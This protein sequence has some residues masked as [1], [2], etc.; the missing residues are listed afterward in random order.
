MSKTEKILRRARALAAAVALVSLPA[1]GNDAI[2][3]PDIGGSDQAA[4]SDQRAANIGRAM[5]QQLRQRGVIL[6][7]PQIA[8]YIQRLGQRL[9]SHSDAPEQPFTF[10]V[11]DDPAINAFAAPGGYI[12]VHTG[13]IDA[14]ETE[15]ELA[16][17]LAHEIAHVT[18]HHI[19]RSVDLANRM[20]IPTVAALLAAIALGSQNSE[21]G[22]A[23]LAASQAGAIQLQI[24][25]TRHH[26]KEADWVGI[27]T[28][29]RADFDPRAMAVFFERLQTETRYY[30]R[31]PEFLSTHPVTT[32][33]IS[34]SRSR[35][36]TLPYRQVEDSMEYALVRA[37]VK[38]FQAKSPG[39]LANDL[40]KRIAAGQYRHKDPMRYA[41]A[42]ALRE[43][44]QI[45]EA[46]EEFRDLFERLPENNALR[47][48]LAVTELAAGNPERSLE[49][50]RQGL[51]IYPHDPVLV[52]GFGEALLEQGRITEAHRLL[53]RY[54]TGNRGDAKSYYL[55]AQAEEALGN[56]VESQ[57]AL[58]EY[59]Y[60]Q[61]D[62]A[63]GVQQLELAAKGARGDFYQEERIADRLRRMKAQLE[64]M[65][66]L[67]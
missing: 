17:V 13:L 11:V 45:P 24:D 57:V 65:M 18:Q 44:G 25:F 66:A 63:A 14:S 46:L 31:P 48:E 5:L 9:A 3:L 54:I 12:G 61:G 8:G 33:R 62:L 16:A 59:Y 47:H 22:A 50:Y 10:F 34:D 7:D 42:L 23:A 28:L 32:N 29:A 1:T 39:Q 53:S 51:K 40:R 64:Q 35:A 15:S 41:L 36:E 19:A 49:L 4:L 21:A 38:V 2:R 52:P 37:R 20:T 6:E 26:E 27:Q 58:A 60:L 30:G 67:K 55:L 43:S 56:T